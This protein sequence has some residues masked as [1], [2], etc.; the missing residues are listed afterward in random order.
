MKA[1]EMIHLLGINAIVTIVVFTLL[2]I[3][4]TNQENNRLIS[5]NSH[6]ENAPRSGE[7]QEFAQRASK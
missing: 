1:N 2:I 7:V 4:A 3:F 6:L 5:S